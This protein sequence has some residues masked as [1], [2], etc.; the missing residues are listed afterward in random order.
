MKRINNKGFLLVETLIVAVF[1]MTIFT[2]LYKNSVPLMGEYERRY[3]YDDIDSVYGADLV[4]DM[5]ISDANYNNLIS[6]LASTESTLGIPFKDITDCSN[7]N[8]REFCNALKTS[9][10]IVPSNINNANDGKIYLMRYEL[11]NLKNAV[12]EGKAFN[13]STERGIKSYVEFIPKF[14]VSNI[15]EGYR[16][17]IVRNTKEGNNETVKYANIE[18]RK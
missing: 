5:I 1:I 14:T 7:F 9:L 2:F 13:S 3:N 4:R 11:S 12:K 10:G 15:T 18:V 8:Q 17:I 16:V 6:G